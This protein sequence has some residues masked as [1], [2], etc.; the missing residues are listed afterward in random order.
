MVMFADTASVT[1]PTLKQQRRKTRFRPVQIAPQYALS[2]LGHGS[3]G[4]VSD[5][6]VRKVLEAA[7][8]EG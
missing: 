1:D 4:L 7:Q 8:A 3:G 6:E 2:G 5:F